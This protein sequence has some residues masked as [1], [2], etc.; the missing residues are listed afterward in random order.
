MLTGEKYIEFL[1]NAACCIGELAVR[2][3]EADDMASSEADCRYNQFFNATAKFQVLQGYFPEGEYE[4]QPI[5]ATA[6]LDLTTIDA[7]TLNNGIEFTFTVGGV[8]QYT[9][10]TIN[11]YGYTLTQLIANIVSQINAAGLDFKAIN[12]SGIVTVQTID[13]AASD[14]NGDTVSLD[15][16]SFLTTISSARLGTDIVNEYCRDSSG[17]V[18]ITGLVTGNIYQVTGTTITDTLS[19]GITPGFYASPVYSPTTNALYVSLQEVT[20]TNHLAI[21]QIASPFNT[22]TIN[23]VTLPLVAIGSAPECRPVYNPFDGH[24]YLSR[25]AAGANTVIYKV[26]PDS[27]VAPTLTSTGITGAQFDGGFVPVA[28][29]YTGVMIFGQAGS[30]NWI[31]I[32]TNLTVTPINNASS[33]QARLPFIQIGSSSADTYF[34]VPIPSSMTID[35]YNSDLDTPDYVIIVPSSNSPIGFSQTRKAL[36]YGATSN[37]GLR[38]AFFNSDITTGMSGVVINTTSAVTINGNYHTDEYSA[39]GTLFNIGTKNAQANWMSIFDDLD[40]SPFTD[41][42]DGGV[43]GIIREAGVNCITAEKAQVVMDS[44]KSDCTLC[45]CNSNYER[46][47]DPT[48]T[49]DL[50][51]NNFL[52]DDDG[53][54]ILTDEGDPILIV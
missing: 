6:Q 12:N 25:N 20:G 27:L 1:D 14:Y 38:L 36:I 30:N 49:A 16:G 51:I 9:G 39:D 15:I 3:I 23:Y 33:P 35:L 45:Q 41:T 52:V 46:T 18:Y 31:F 29:P 4:V 48:P 7:A 43:D 13:A 22:S 47:P 26:A 54:L 17:L 40:Y 11:A 44:L 37:L 28:N 21:I 32:D 19:L 50:P 5:K 42:I 2:A 24:V 53:N 34:M 10:T 8:L